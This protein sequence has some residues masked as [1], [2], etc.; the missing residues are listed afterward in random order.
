MNSSVSNAWLDYF[1]VWFFSIRRWLWSRRSLLYMVAVAVRLF[2]PPYLLADVNGVSGDEPE[3]RATSAGRAT[4]FSERSFRRIMASRTGANVPR[5]LA[6]RRTTINAEFTAIIAARP[7]DRNVTDIH[8]PNDTNDNAAAAAASKFGVTRSCVYYWL[9]VRASFLDWRI[10]CV[11]R[12][13]TFR[14]EPPAKYFRRRGHGFAETALLFKDAPAV[15]RPP[16]S[17]VALEKRQFPAF[18]KRDVAFHCTLFFFNQ[19]ALYTDG[20]DWNV[21]NRKRIRLPSSVD[22]FARNQTSGSLRA[23]FWA[24]QKYNNRLVG[25]WVVLDYAWGNYRKNRKTFKIYIYTD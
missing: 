18:T 22:D 1:R 12:R 19:S 23:A 17:Y 6:G 15:E 10:S 4:A 20:N 13:R 2:V 14:A 16:L 9:S 21:L 3:E 5:P 7:D 8:W 25:D 11:R 24:F